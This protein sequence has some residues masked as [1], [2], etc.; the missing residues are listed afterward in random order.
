MLLKIDQAARERHLRKTVRQHDEIHVARRNLLAFGGKLPG[1]PPRRKG[2]P[3]RPRLRP[4]IWSW[5]NAESLGLDT[6]DLPVAVTVPQYLEQKATIDGLFAM[7]FGLYTHLSP[8]PPVTGGPKLVELLTEGLESLT[9]GQVAL[10][11]DPKTAADGIEAHL[12][13]KREALGMPVLAGA[14]V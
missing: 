4:R 14:P 3:G 2:R 13:A 1:R 6:K 11:D 10:G 9:G 7:A 12:N 8:T 5:Y